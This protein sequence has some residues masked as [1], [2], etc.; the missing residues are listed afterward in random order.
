M[1][2]MDPPSED[3]QGTGPLPPGWRKHPMGEC[4]KAMVERRIKSHDIQVITVQYGDIETGLTVVK[5]GQDDSLSCF[6][7]DV[8]DWNFF[9]KNRE[10]ILNVYSI[11][12]F[13]SKILEFI[14]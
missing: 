10:K 7:S 13:N 12:E 1:H 11:K 14:R 5:K 6:S 8:L 3:Y 2:D 9:V 4:W